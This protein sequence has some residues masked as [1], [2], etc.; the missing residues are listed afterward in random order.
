[1]RTRLTAALLLAA[2]NAV[3]SVQCFDLSVTRLHEVH[4]QFMEGWSVGNYSTDNPGFGQ[5]EQFTVL[6]G[7]IKKGG[8]RWIPFH[9]E[10]R[11]RQINSFKSP[12]PVF[13]ARGETEVS[14]TRTLTEEG[15]LTFTRESRSHGTWASVKGPLAHDADIWN[16]RLDLNTGRYE[17]IEADHAIDMYFRELYRRGEMDRTTVLQARAELVPTF[18][19]SPDGDDGWGAIAFS[20]GLTVRG[21]VA[22]LVRED[23]AI[24]CAA[25]L[26]PVD[27]QAGSQQAEVQPLSTDRR[28]RPGACSRS[29]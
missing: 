13:S 23:G 16:A 4:A 6:Q 12:P 5:P 17:A 27:A 9:S 29:P 15:I 21:S 25:V 11:Y 3:A 18:C 2:G 20:R 22:A 19:A 8:S 28:L 14:E 10:S 26:V 7:V 24:T 1:M